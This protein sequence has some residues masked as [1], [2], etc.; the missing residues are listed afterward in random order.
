MTDMSS[1]HMQAG[2][3]YCRRISERRIKRGLLFDGEWN[4]E[5]IC[6]RL[7]SELSYGA[8]GNSDSNQSGTVFEQTHHRMGE[9]EKIILEQTEKCDLMIIDDFGAEKELD[10]NQTGWRAEKN[11]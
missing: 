7:Y 1:S 8:R 9:G 3:R 6:K 4:R 5:D 10:K 2:K 11:I